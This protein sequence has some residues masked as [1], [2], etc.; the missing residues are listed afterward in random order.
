[1]F[2]FVLNQSICIRLRTFDLLGPDVYQIDGMAKKTDNP[3]MGRPRGF[4]SDGRE[5]AVDSQLHPIHE[6]RI[7]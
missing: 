4:D 2:F 6:A 3:K 7:V 1:M 5:A